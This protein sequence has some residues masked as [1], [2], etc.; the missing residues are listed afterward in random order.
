MN[1]AALEYSTDSIV[2][3]GDRAQ[4]GTGQPSQHRYAA[5]GQVTRSVRLAGR[6]QVEAAV[7]AARAAF[8]AWRDLDPNVR[9][10]KLLRF[11]ALVR[12]KVAVL[13]AVTTLDAGITAEMA[14]AY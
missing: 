6:D 9:R 4:P 12:E 10:D 3:I 8:P 13:A 2:L 5:N 11:A 7:A 1:S 14:V